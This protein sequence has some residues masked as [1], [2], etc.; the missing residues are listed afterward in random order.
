[1]WG[2]VIGQFC[3]HLQ[4]FSGMPDAATD[5][6]TAASALPRIAETIGS[7]QRSGAAEFPLFSCQVLRV[8]MSKGVTAAAAGAG[9]LCLSTAVTQR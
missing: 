8:N 2:F 5:G 6:Q 7:C 3:G 9:P 1:M 4:T